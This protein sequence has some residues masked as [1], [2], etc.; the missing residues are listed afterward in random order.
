MKR[1]WKTR[2]QRPL[3]ISLTLDFLLFNCMLLMLVLGVYIFI[4]IDVTINSG[5]NVIADANLKIEAREYRGQ[6]AN[7]IENR[8]LL[9][10]GGWLEVLDNE[11]NV[12]STVGEKRDTVSQYSEDAIYE[13]LENRKDQSYYYSMARMDEAHHDAG[14]LLLKIP[15]DRVK[16]SINSD[17]LEVYLNQSVSFYV[18]VGTG[19][20]ILLTVIYSYWVARRIKKPLRIITLGLNQMTEGNYSMRIKLYAEKEFARIGDTFNYMAGV[21][22]RTTREKAQA[23]ASKQQLMVDLSHDLKTPITSIQGY[24]QALVEGRGEDKERQTRYLTYIYNKSSQ[25]TKLIQNTLELLKIDS[26]DFLLRVE[27]QELGE[28]LRE[29]VA[30]TYGEIEQK[31]FDLKLNVPDHEVMASYDAELLSRVIHNL[32]ANAL[33]YNPPGTRLR[34]ELL[35]SDDKIAIEI[36]D[37]GIGIPQE[38]WPTIF[39]PF[40]RGDEARTASGGTGLG[41]SIAKRNTEKMG[42]TLHLSR[43]G[44]DATIFTIEIP[45]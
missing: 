37:N 6:P 39:D 45:K 42:G 26:P 8:R 28:F 41:L 7:G 34:V 3:H 10:S 25:V 36:A 11:R 12:V 35:P 21:I 30:E 14:W 17:P 44:K 33:A 24:A 38:L 1:P 13:A 15:R 40:V 18:F 22:E 29:I 9:E 16:I 2:D 43:K 27:R 23:E 32:I 19:L 4:N 31:N 5:K 20:I